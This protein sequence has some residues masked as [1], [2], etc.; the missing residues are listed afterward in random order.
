MIGASKISIITIV[1]NDKDGLQK[2]IDSVASLN[3]H[4]I[5]FI[6]IDGGSSDGTAELIQ[7]CEPNIDYWVSEADDAFMMQ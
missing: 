4:N 7:K 1:Y 5:E 3:Y 2:T 6:V